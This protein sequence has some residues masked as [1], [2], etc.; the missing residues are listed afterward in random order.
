[1][2]K[3]PELHPAGV[4]FFAMDPQGI[5]QGKGNALMKHFIATTLVAAAMTTPAFAGNEMAAETETAVASDVMLNGFT[6][7]SDWVSKPVFDSE[8]QRIGEVERVSY[9]SEGYVDDIVVEAGGMLDIGG[10]EILVTAEEYTVVT[11]QGDED[12]AEIRVNM[13]SEEFVTLPAFDEDLVSDYPLSDNDLIDGVDE[14]Q[15]E[16]DTEIG[17][18]TELELDTNTDL[19]FK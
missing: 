2:Q 8:G 12:E 10:E 16:A 9:D 13:T 5:V 18:E 17:V 6:D 7:Q 4:C 19:D 3:M 15:G 11:A 1:M 14:S